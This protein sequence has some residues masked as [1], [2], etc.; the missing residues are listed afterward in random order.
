MT[1]SIRSL[2][3]DDILRC[4]EIATRSC[5]AD[6]KSL[7]VT[8]EEVKEEFSLPNVDAGRD[9]FVA[10]DGDLVV[11]YSYTYMLHNPEGDQRCYVFGHVDPPHRRRGVGRMLMDH[12]VARARV[13]LKS[14]PCSGSSFLRADCPT[15]NIGAQALFASHGMEPVRWFSNLWRPL[16]HLPQLAPP[17]E[18]EI[19]AWDPERNETLR[20]VKNTA[21]ADHWGSTPTSV[22]NWEQL[23]MGSAARL[24]LSF[25]ARVGERT[26]GLLLTHRYP[27]DDEV[28][29]GR[30]GWIDKLA[31]IPDWRARGVASSLIGSALHAYEQQGLTH[32][33]LD[34]DTSSQTGANRLYERLGFTLKFLTV[35]WS[36]ST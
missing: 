28:V 5:L 8:A 35:T 13:I 21:F 27:H 14:S 26:V 1:L 6:G 31:T 10:V 2:H 4:A 24:D 22:E 3:P 32:A 11:G 25:E 23:T 19:V 29:G 18:F 33:A 20:Q 16:Q 7:V 9:V 36:L 30:F 34:V 12:A 17:T 15:T